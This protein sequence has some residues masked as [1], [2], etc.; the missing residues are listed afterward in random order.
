LFGML[1]LFSCDRIP[2]GLLT[3]CPLESGKLRFAALT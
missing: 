1:N 3:A 2:A